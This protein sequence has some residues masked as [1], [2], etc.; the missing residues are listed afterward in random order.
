MPLIGQNTPELIERGEA[1]FAEAQRHDEA[2]RAGRAIRGYD[3]VA[4]RHPFS[5][6]AA[7]ARFRQAELIQ[8]QGDVVKS[9]EAYQQFID[10]FSGSGLYSTALSRQAAMA[11]SAA[12]GE[13][14]SGFLGLRTRISLERTVGMLEQVRENAPRSRTASK[15]QFTA[16]QLYESRKKPREAVE[17]YRKLV[18]EQPDAPE[19]PEALFRIGEVMLAQAEA[20]NRNQATLDLAREAFNDYLIQYPRHAKNAD[21]RRR[22]AEIRD[23][24]L[25][26]TLETAKFYERSGRIESAKVYYREVVREAK[27]GPFHDEA[28]ARLREL[29]EG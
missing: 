23:R 7:Q 17:A 21:A 16:G 6:S 19:A 28:R 3:R 15:A 10:R 14:R 29:G 20:G 18:R 26:R 4:T 22:L 27:S 12:E 25:E 24:N 5:P 9:F 8:E 11:Q 1:L 13:V 2:G